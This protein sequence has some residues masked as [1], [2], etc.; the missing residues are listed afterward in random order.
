MKLLFHPLA[1]KEF[2]ISADW[3]KKRSVKVE[4]RF[5]ESVFRTIDFII[6]NPKVVRKIRG[7]K[8]SARVNG[9]PF[10]ILYIVDSDS[11]FIVSVFHHSRNPKSWETR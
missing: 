11:V 6:K 2:E 8:R 9:F 7:E 1:K 5:I 3:Y 10:S 4:K